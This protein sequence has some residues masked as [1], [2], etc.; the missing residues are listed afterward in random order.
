ML[1]CRKFAMRWVS[2]YIKK[3]GSS[4]TKTSSPKSSSQ[5]KGSGKRIYLLNSLIS[6]VLKFENWSVVS[7]LSED[8]Y[9]STILKEN[10]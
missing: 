4:S 10:N 6:T 9:L 2:R 3:A 8:S 7:V 5:T 1:K